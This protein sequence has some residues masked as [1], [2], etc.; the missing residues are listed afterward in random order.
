MSSS[1]EPRGRISATWW[2]DL[3]SAA[4][5]LGS[6]VQKGDVSPSAEVSGV[7]WC[8]SPCDA[9]CWVLVGAKGGGGGDSRLCLTSSYLAIRGINAG[10]TL[11]WFSWMEGWVVPKEHFLLFLFPCIAPLPEILHF[12]TKPQPFCQ[13][14]NVHHSPPTP[15][16]SSIIWVI[17]ASK[18]VILKPQAL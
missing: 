7:V 9:C 14:M 2:Q 17:S 10:P 3:N 13:R 6:S 18:A 1:A 15:T 12:H 4:T 8:T 16:P 11:Q 5:G